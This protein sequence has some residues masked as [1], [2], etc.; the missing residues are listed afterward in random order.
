MK[1]I[2]AQISRYS[3]LL[4]LCAL[5]FVLHGPQLISRTE[6][7]QAQKLNIIFDLG[8]VLVKTSAFKSL[9][10]IGFGTLIK[11]KLSTRKES[12]ELK[13]LFY[14]TLD[15]TA[16]SQGNTLG[17][18]DDEG[19]AMPALMCDWLT[20][21][22]TTLQLRIIILRNIRNHP[23]WFENKHEQLLVARIVQMTF[24]PKTF[25]KTRK[26]IKEG[27]AF[28]RECKARGHNL[29]ILSN[30]DAETF[31]LMVQKYPDEF[32]LFDG[33]ITS[34]DVKNMK[35]NL[36]IY[37]HFTDLLPAESCLFFDDQIENIQAAQSLGIH[38]FHCAK[39]KGS[40]QPDFKAACSA[41]EKLEY[42]P[43]PRITYETIC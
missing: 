41:L 43:A 25:V 10:A 36:S 24:T 22:K 1:V 28:V 12:S 38:T 13:S 16:G 3:A 2:M 7:N 31:K 18:K 29:F 39:K 32:G 5:P 37:K 33:A 26:L 23:E 14:Q 34:G 11:W 9:Q 20:G 30:W 19:H 4:L 42:V 40:S 15:R 8:G 17:A 27:F 35:P 6:Q 21:A